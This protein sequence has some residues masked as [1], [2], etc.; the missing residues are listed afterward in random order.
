VA[1]RLLTGTDLNGQRAVN[2]ADAVS[3]TDLTTLEQVQAAIAS[4]VSGLTYK[5]SVRVATTSALPAVT[6]TAQTLTETAAGP[7]LP[8]IDGVA[9]SVNDRILVKNQVTTAQNGIYVVSNLGGV[10]TPFVL[11]RAAD[12]NSPSGLAEGSTAVV[13][14]GT[15]NADV[16]YTQITTGAIVVGTT[17]LVYV[18]SSATTYTAGNGLQL[19]ANAFSIL[20]Q[21][22]PGLQVSGLGLA[23]L[24]GTNS[25]LTRTSGLSVLLD[26]TPGLVLGAGGLKVDYSTITRK[27]SFASTSGTT[28]TCTH[29]FGTTDVLVGI[30]DQ[31]SF[32]QVYA[33]SVSTSINVVTV[34]FGAS[35]GAGAYRITVMG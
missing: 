14:E 18:N 32:A 27:A 4:A 5:Q 31:T 6:A 35:V 16:Q 21:S 28:T 15:A 22:T 19:I 10:S 29:N 26:S 23:V 9:L 30:I 13:G 7:A 20:L 24:L 12:S 33:D 3:P 1:I 2:A 11:T 25:G 17:G 8:S 34:T